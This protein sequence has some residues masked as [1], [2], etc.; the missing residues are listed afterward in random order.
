MNQCPSD[1]QLQRMLADALTASE[2]LDAHVENCSACQQAIERLQ[3]ATRGFRLVQG[4]EPTLVG[5]GTDDDFLQ[6]LAANPMDTV[7][8]GQETNIDA[9]RSSGEPPVVAGYEIVRELGKGGMGVVYQAWHARLR[10]FVALKMVLAGSRAGASELARFRIEAEAAARLQHPNIVQVHDV[11][12]QDGQPFLTLEFV[13]G[14]SLANVTQGRP[15][16]ADEAARLVQTLAEAMHYAHQR[17]ILHR[18]L[19]PANIL[20]EM[21]EP[22]RPNNDTIDQSAIPSLQSAIPKITDF[23]LAKLTVGGSDQTQSGCVLGTPSYMA[24]EQAGGKTKEISTAVDIY[25]LGVILYEL[26]TG[27]PPFRGETA[28]ETLQQVL[29]GQP[30]SL[31]SLQANVPADLETICLKCLE[32]EPS[33]R[34]ASAA[35]LAEDLR[36]FREDEPIHARPTGLWK[37]TRKWAKRKPAAATLAAVLALSVVGFAAGAWWYFVDVGHERDRATE[38]KN[39]AERKRLEAEAQR[40]QARHNLYLADIPLAQRAWEAARVERLRKLLDSTQPEF[41]DQKD[42]RHFEWYYLRHLTHTDLRTLNGHGGQVTAVAFDADGQRLASASVD[43]AIKLWRMSDGEELLALKGRLERV[44]SVAFSPDGKYLAAGS[45]D[46]RVHLWNAETGQELWPF[47]GH[48]G[49]VYQVAFSPN[50]ERLASASTDKTIKIWDVAD[51]RVLRTLY[52][53]G[54]VVT[55]VTFSPNNLLLAS[56]SADHTVRLWDLDGE[57]QTK[58][59]V[60]YGHIGWVYGVA[61]SPDGRTVASSSFDNIVRTWDTGS[62]EQRHKMWGHAGQIRGVAFSP[63][64]QR[65]ASAGFD[66]TVRIW[67][68]VAGKQ[69]LSLKGHIGHVN[70]VAF[71]PDGKR[72]ATG[73]EDH[74]VKI[75]DATRVQEYCTAQSHRVGSASALAFSPNGKVLVSGGADTLIRLWDLNAAHELTPF[76]GHTNKVCAVAFTSDSK[77]LASGGADLT[78]RLW[79]TETGQQQWSVGSH[80]D[81]ISSLAFNHDDTRLASASFDGWVK[82]WSWDPQGAH[83]M[84]KINA[85][86][87]RVEGVVFSP[88][89]NQVASCGSDRKIHLWNTTDGQKLRTLES[90]TDWIYC[91]A[92]SPDGRWLASGSADGTIQIWNS[93]TGQIH[94]TLEGHAGRVNSVAFSPDGQRL[95]SAGFFDHTV[96]L[97]ELTRGQELLSLKHPNF[98]LTVAF[99]P[100]GW[101]IASLG[102]DSLVRIWDA[103]PSAGSK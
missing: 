49:S 103:N 27:R 89:G 75:W 16:P 37:R 69:L 8:V 96:K 65:L 39:D 15:L 58:S 102:G 3:A 101:R 77:H 14:G 38:A 33:Q 17:G 22:I 94:L 41:A 95:A 51:R 10:R 47:L 46:K 100:D 6:R 80:K 43:G 35:D 29:R 98:V 81:L 86:A 45:E 2:G 70:C 36:R 85:H 57:Q 91:V 87:G 62:G 50:G 30:P 88:D 78:I 34:Y 28:V 73:G 82:I 72:V 7:W 9:V 93:A 97:W 83:E 5:Q 13:A 25:A 48:N 92:Y 54:D 18:D 56:A 55:A 40:D 42:L 67:D 11:G 21:P 1:L 12:E 19:K 60:L 74:S 99:S 24:P 84:L 68:A 53:H 63:D 90:H 31:R 52:G 44:N 64:G 59:R 71:H 26:L 76:Q 66:Q 20:L 61:F 32:T 23:G 79:D 4:E